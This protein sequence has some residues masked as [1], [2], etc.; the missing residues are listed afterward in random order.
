MADGAGQEL[1]ERGVALQ[2][3]LAAQVP[4]SGRRDVVPLTEMREL[5]DFEGWER[6]TADRG[7]E[8]APGGADRVSVLVDVSD[9]TQVS[10]RVSTTSVEQCHGDSLGAWIAPRLRR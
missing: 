7:R 6:G 9:S 2:R 5:G 3:D 4:V 8:A 1:V 10:L